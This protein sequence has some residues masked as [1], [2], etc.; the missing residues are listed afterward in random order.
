L[1][2]QKARKRINERKRFGVRS[3]ITKYQKQIVNTFYNE[4]VLEET[5]DKFLKTTGQESLNDAFLQYLQEVSFRT[6]DLLK[7]ARELLIE[8]WTKG[9]KRVQDQEGNTVSFDE[10]IDENAIN[11]LIKKQEENYKSLSK[12]QSKAVD[13]IISEGLEKGE[14]VK[15]ITENIKSRVK[16]ITTNSARRIARSEIVASHSAGQI[17]T[18]QKAGIEHYSFINSPEYTGKDGKTYPCIICRKLQGP[19]GRER[20]YEVAKAGSSENNPLPVMQS[21][22]SCQCLIV[23]RTDK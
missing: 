11:L 12:Q 8:S 14:S 4:K 3:N 13:K 22:P 20:I 10:V 17:Q 9:T 7:D 19:K 16:T 6:K 21:H 5:L 2:S 1:V 18:M 15:E 23:V